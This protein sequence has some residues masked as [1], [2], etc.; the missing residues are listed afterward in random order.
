MISGKDFFFAS[1]ESL[2][3]YIKGVLETHPLFVRLA[4]TAEVSHVEPTPLTT[5]E[6]CGDGDAEFFNGF[7]GKKPRKQTKR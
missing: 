2:E 5:E 3:E 6:L 1:R 7:L 4:T